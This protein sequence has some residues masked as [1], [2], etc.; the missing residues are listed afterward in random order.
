MSQEVN[1]WLELSAFHTIN[2]WSL[3]FFF[4]FFEFR[5]RPLRG[6]ELYG[7]LGNI[8]LVSHLPPAILVTPW[9][10]ITILYFREQHY[11]PPDSLIFLN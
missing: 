4:F 5:S 8:R 11:D 6:T 10:T 9:D 7:R 3:F 2:V 1:D